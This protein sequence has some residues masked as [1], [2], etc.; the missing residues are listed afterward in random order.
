MWDF[1]N[2][3]ISNLVPGL[4]YP[5]LVALIESI[6]ATLNTES[7]I[8]LTSSS[9]LYKIWYTFTN[10]WWGIGTPLQDT[11]TRRWHL[12][13][14]F[15]LIL[16]SYGSKKKNEAINCFV[17]WINDY[18]FIY[19]QFHPDISKLLRK[20]YLVFL[21]SSGKSKHHLRPA[22]F[23]LVEQVSN[24]HRLYTLYLVANLLIKRNLCLYEWME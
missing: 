16:K 12:R 2:E 23:Q 22:L 17:V 21:L 11:S 9:S 18:L 19:L 5:I 4:R 6:L 10:C 15:N 13:S 20:F 14:A 8:A 1:L 3:N 7:G 24:K